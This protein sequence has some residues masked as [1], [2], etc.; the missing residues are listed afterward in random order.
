MNSRQD[1][2]YD[3]TGFDADAYGTLRH[4]AAAATY[5]FPNLADRHTRSTRLAM[6]VGDLLQSAMICGGI[7]VM[8]FT[9]RDESL[10]VVACEGDEAVGISVIDPT[11]EIP[12]DVVTWVEP[13]HEP[14]VEQVL[15]VELL[16]NARA[17]GIA[18]VNVLRGTATE[19]V[20]ESLG[21]H[22]F[23]ESGSVARQKIAWCGIRGT[24]SL[25][26]VASSAPDLDE[27]PERRYG[28]VTRTGRVPTSRRSPGVRGVDVPS[29]R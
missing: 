16:R 3:L 28:P 23:Q 2:H 15:K 26:E 18:R 22:D 12:R 8:P 11:G 5:H 14:W 25:I 24:T 4:R 19:A 10:V 9:I 6:A 29:R 7:D 17:A 21:L 27:A 13:T 1:R 20:Y